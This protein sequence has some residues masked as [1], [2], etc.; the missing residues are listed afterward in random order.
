MKK[1]AHSPAILQQNTWSFQMV[2]SASL[3]NMNRG[4][5][6]PWHVRNSYSVE[7]RDQHQPT[8]KG[9]WEKTKIL[10]EANEKASKEEPKDQDFAS[11]LHD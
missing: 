8:V 1:L 3:S 2:F 9:V 4:P 7:D 6:S 11:Q 10:Q 5:K